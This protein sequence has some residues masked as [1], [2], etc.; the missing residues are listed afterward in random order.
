MIGLLK[1]MEAR[2]FDAQEVIYKEV[3]DCNDIIFV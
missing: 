2:Y 3:E 1:N